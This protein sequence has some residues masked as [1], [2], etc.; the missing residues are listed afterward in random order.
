ML[1]TVAYVP[2]KTSSWSRKDY[3]GLIMETLLSLSK[4]I[5]GRRRAILVDDFNC[6]E[7]HK[8]GITKFVPKYK[9][10]EGGKKDWFNV[11]AKK[12]RDEAWKKMDEK[13][14]SEKQGKFKISK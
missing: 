3:E 13:Q 1:I 5:K 9:P 8:I 12:K 6:K 4:V 2:P 14:K 11:R 7:V 10:R